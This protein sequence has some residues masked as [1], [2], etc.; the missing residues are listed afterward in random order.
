MRKFNDTKKQFK[1]GEQRMKHAFS[2]RFLSVFLCIALIMTYL[3]IS[4]MAASAS[5]DHISRVSEP[6]T[7]D[8]WRD[9]FLP[10]AT[11]STENAGGVWMDK[12]VFTDNS[13]LSYT[14]ITMN[15]SDA[16]LVALSA[17]ATNM[18]VTGMSHVP[19]DTMLILDVSASMGSGQNNVA[20]ELIEAANESIHS[21]LSTNSH[22][23]VGVVLYS[24]P[25][26]QGGSATSTD[27]VLVLPLGRYTTG[28]DDK[29]LG[30]SKVT[31]GSGRNQTTTETVS[32]DTDLVYEGTTTK[33]S[34]TSKNV[35]GG[36]YIQ[37][38]VKLAADQLTADGLDTTINDLVLG[39]IKRKPVMVLMSDGAP[40]FSSTNFQNPT[41][42]NLGD[43]TST[44]AA[45]GFVN[46]LTAAY[47][48]NLVEE[49]YGT[50][51]L[52]YTIGL[53]VSNDSIALSVLDPDNEDASTAINDFWEQW[54]AASVGRNITVQSGSWGTSARTVTKIDGLEQNYVDEFINVT[55]SGSGQGSLGDRLIQAFADIVSNINLQS[56]YKPTLI[57]QVGENHSGYITFI[58]KIGEYME[59]TDIKGI[60]INDTLYSGADLASNFVS[61]GGNLGTYDNPTE[62][63][64]EMVAT[65][66]E[67]IGLTNDDEAR[68]LIGLAYEY[69]Q[70]KYN[71]ATDYSNYIGWYA[72]KDS[73]F[74]GFY[75]EGVT[76]I[77]DANAVY[78]IKSYGYL[79]VEH[80]SNMMYATV[81]VRKNIKTGEETV[82]FAVPASLIPVMTYNVSLDENG[83]LLDIAL[84]GSEEPIRLVYEVALDDNIN[85]WNVKE[86][87]SAEYLADEH[88]VNVDGSVNFYTN[89]WEHTNSTGYNTVNTYSY[90]NPSRQNDKYYFTADAPIYSDTDGTLYEGS[91]APDVNGTYYNAFTVYI[92]NGAA[93]YKETVYRQLSSNALG[94]AMQTEGTNNWHIPSGDVHVNLDGYT[95]DKDINATGTLGIANQ[96]F[97]DIYGHNVSDT[98]HSFYVGATLG[99]NGRLTLTPQTGIKLSKEMADGVAAPNTPFTFDIFNESDVYDGS[100][101][102]A[103]LVKAD[104][105]EVETSVLFDDGNATVELYAGEV[106]YIGD[107]PNGETFR[108]VERESAEYIATATGLS[109]SGTVTVVAN[110]IKS[111]AFE[112]D[113]R[114]T[115]NL[116][117]AKEVEHDFGQDYQ[118]PA[119]KV[120][121]MQVTLSG[122]GTANATFKASH[123]NGSYTNITTD[124][125][126]QFTVQLKHDEQF[127]VFGLPAGTT[128]TVVEKNPA[129]GFTPAYWD[130]GQADDGVVTVVKNST[131]SVIVVNDYTA[132]EVYPINIDLGG[133]KTV[134]NESGSVVTDWP[135]NYE[136][137]IV[138]E[139]FDATNGWTEIGR[140][141]LDKDNTTFDFNDVMAKEKYTAPGV[142][143]YQL[144][145]V[146][147]ALTDASR[148]PGMM[149]DQTW[150]TFSVYVSDADMDGQLEIVRVHSEHADK[151]FELVNGEYVIA[152]DVVNTQTAEVPALITVDVQKKL[153]NDS[154]SPL[155]TLSGYKFGLYTDADCTQEAAIGNGVKS[156]D[157]VATDAIGEGWIDIQFDEVGEYTFYVKELAGSNAQMQ[158][159]QQ[160]IKVVV[161]VEQSGND[162]VATAEYFNADGSPYTLNADGEVEITNTYNPKDTELAID[163]VSKQL[164]GRAMTSSDNFTFEVQT[165]EGATVLKGSNSGT[166]KVTFN[167]TLK[168]D[169]V[170]TYFYNIVETSADGN[171]VTV[172]KTTYRMTVTVVDDNGALK[173]TYVIVNA[174]GDSIVFKNIYKAVDTTYAISGQKN[175]TGRALLNDEFTFV[176]TEALNAQGEIAD[177]AKTYEAHNEFGGQF[178]FPEITYTAAGTYYYVVTEKQN[179][180]SSYGIN[181]DTSKYVV[182]VTVRDDTANGKLVAS[183]NLGVNDIVFNNR[184]VAA[185]VSKRIDGEK[186]LNGKTLVGGQ[187]SFELWQSN[188]EWTPVNAQPIQ[189]VANDG[190][191]NFAFNFV[192]YTNNNASDFTKAGTYYY[193]IKEVN[194]GQTIK[195]ITYDDIIYRVRVEI[196][197]DLLGQLHATAHIYDNNGVPQESIIFNNSYE[198][199]GDNYLTVSGTK[200]LNNAVPENRAFEFELY[201]ANDAYEIDGNYIQ[202]VSQNAN[203]SFEFTINYKPKDISDTPY[204]YVVK[205]TNAGQKLNGVTYDD[206]VY[207]IEVMVED[208]GEGGVKSTAIIRKGESIV[209]SL[210]FANTYKADSVGVVFDGEKVLEGNRKVKANNYTFEIFNANENFETISSAAPATKNDAER[211]FEF[212]EITL[213]TAKT[214]YFVVKENSE[215]ALNGVT[216]DTSKY[217]IT[218][219]VID[220][221]Q[222]GRLEVE[223]ITYVRVKGENSADANGILFENS[224]KASNATVS[225]AGSK[226]LENRTLAE[227]EFKFFL[228]PANEN[229]VVDEEASVMEAKNN[230]DGSFSFDALTFEEIGTYYFVISEDAETTAERVTNDTSVYHV[231]IEVKDDEDGKLYEAGRVIKKVGSDAAVEEIT[232]NNVFTPKPEDITVDIGVAKTVVNKGSEKIG[233]DGFEF[234]LEDT[235]TNEK[236]NV[237]S[238]TAGNANF[239]LGYTEND[240]GKTYTYKLT[241]INGGKANV[242]YSTAEYTITVAISLNESNELVA[243]LTKN[244]ENAPTVVAEFENVYDYT[245]TPPNPEYPDSPQTGDATNL[246]LW[247]AL[248]FVSG[249][250]IF[251]TALYGRKRKEEEAN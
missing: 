56:Q 207:H 121:T 227:N 3:P 27:A 49:K 57:S 209:T 11:I 55:N 149:Y 24:G 242:S 145:E 191:G 6:S 91:S 48:K 166:E 58:D 151:D 237:K 120:F 161:K 26:T 130:N 233:P 186:V 185:S 171:G 32:L 137:D 72:D 103:L 20:S 65:V 154:G 4:A 13:D 81:Q 61:G 116:T 251:G 187:F 197:D 40:T 172:D 113:L 43:G 41:S 184:Y 175:L 183:A 37:K 93:H 114:G 68:T 167:G 226:T 139:R 148:V 21:L 132:T 92:E 190:D 223:S 194:G 14:G 7:M 198:I 107:L 230:A 124:A 153:N 241:E 78:T 228:Y 150:H 88:N 89:A 140:K 202:K 73:N 16:F 177:G 234:V 110:E 122:I 123:T 133:S 63:G 28:S 229:Y 117:V 179:S 108:I 188:D 44:S 238:D 52:F 87:L 59:V 5:S 206:T 39:T 54:N 17:M 189:T 125:N 69:G 181:F 243:T 235:A 155:V 222:L 163:F 160:V 203:G 250:G 33:P 118:I 131:V 246:H 146:D 97:V 101:Y 30:Y 128:A 25:T 74:L 170:G 8:S 165:Q 60:L 126:G 51:P 142:Y 244:G 225:I 192:D 112:N 105:S 86:V 82:A 45:Q 12:S 98:N 219:K 231:A 47:A 239:T 232:F 80:D 247:F 249:G 115:G 208:N 38:G 158:Y 224:Y 111:V 248:L 213:D 85:E 164:N 168:F 143:S 212:N 211:K 195:G 79:G 19:T 134:K 90:F 76:N 46:Q 136:F 64:H 236:W 104:G 147:P 217:H 96:P 216:Y 204:Y 220:N 180:G 2:K 83:E 169:K 22:N 84:S 50:A 218:V 221:E 157:I 71:S 129:T 66:R 135:D 245:P 1:E 205:E 240:I 42:I 15:D 200:K 9:F 141:T 138:L 156:I 144:Y 95:I 77:T 109:D 201:K 100:I 18:T 75:Q 174:T 106:L 162:Y 173:A 214:Y 35:V 34:T 196:T 199:T 210:D 10:G 152:I 94:T 127:E 36:T 215:N 102:P 193:L 159:S 70:I 23:R 176:L 178:T 119:D 29:Y 67:R 99:N 53:G 62:L 31:T 182:T